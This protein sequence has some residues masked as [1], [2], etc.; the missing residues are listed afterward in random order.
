M[1]APYLYNR[2]EL[3]QSPVEPAVFWHRLWQPQD[4]TRHPREILSTKELDYYLKIR[5]IV[6]Y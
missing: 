3:D 5:K 1:H 6:R 4:A 2:R